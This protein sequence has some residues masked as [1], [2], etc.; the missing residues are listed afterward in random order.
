MKN[1][2]HYSVMTESQK[3]LSFLL[4]QNTLI[5]YEKLHTSCNFSLKGTLGEWGCWKEKNKPIVIIRL[6]WTQ[7]TTLAVLLLSLRN[8]PDPTPKLVKK[9]VLCHLLPVFEQTVDDG[10]QDLLWHFAGLQSDNTMH[11]LSQL[12]S[13][14]HINIHILWA[15]ALFSH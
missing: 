12:N 5:K 2:S 3:F 6:F 13:G 4:K 11:T 15:S 9:S 10:F 1:E 8:F 14:Y 7:Y